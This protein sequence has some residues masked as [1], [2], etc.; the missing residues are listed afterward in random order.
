M[1]KVR[2]V[3]KDPDVGKDW[4]Q[5]EKRTSEHEMVGWHHWLDGNEFDQAPG[6]GNGQRSL[7][8]YRPQGQKESNRTEW[9]N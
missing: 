9:L 4:R 1:E 7:T 3:G 8:G 6:V 2:L 5:E